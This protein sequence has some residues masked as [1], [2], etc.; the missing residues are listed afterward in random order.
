MTKEIPLIKFYVGKQLPLHPPPSCQNG[1]LFGQSGIEVVIICRYPPCQSDYLCGSPVWM[2]C[3]DHLFGSFVWTDCM[4]H[5]VCPRIIQ[6]LTSFP[7]IP[8]VRGVLTLIYTSDNSSDNQTIHSTIQPPIQSA[9]CLS[10]QLINPPIQLSNQLGIHPANHSRI[11]PH[12]PPNKKFCRKLN[13][14]YPHRYK[15]FVLCGWYS[16]VSLYVHYEFL[17][18]T[19]T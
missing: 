18:S 12:D 3:L 17:L 5:C 1:G 7:Y 15:W 11:H 4:D 14:V 8:C 19:Y 10:I 16:V 6:G 9:S 2:A 13:N